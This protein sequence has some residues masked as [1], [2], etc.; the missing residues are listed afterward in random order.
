MRFRAGGIETAEV[1][2]SAWC[3]CRD[4]ARLLDLGPVRDLPQLNSFFEQPERAEAQTAALKSLLSGYAAT[5]P[6]VLVTHQV[7]I[8]A[9]A[10]VPTSSGKVVV[11]RLDSDGRVSVL[12]TLPPP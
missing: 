2:S 1:F 6:L 9:L 12:G 10:G 7:D 4:T 5:S 11:A 3:R 8:R